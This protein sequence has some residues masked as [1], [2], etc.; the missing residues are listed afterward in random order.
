MDVL[1]MDRYDPYVPLGFTRVPM[2]RGEA[3]IP[4][5]CDYCGAVVIADTAST[6][7]NSST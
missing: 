7:T 5:T 2:D 6:H 4:Y 3:D 1:L